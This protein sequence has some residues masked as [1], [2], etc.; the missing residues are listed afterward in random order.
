MLLEFVAILAAGFA[1][2]G[3]ALTLNVLLRR[4]LPKWVVPASAG[5]GMLAMAIWLEYSW[6]ERVTANLP[7]EVEVVSTNRLR[8]WYRPWTY[9]VP[10]VNRLIALD[11][12]F[13]RRNPALPDQVLTRVLLLG[14]WEPSRQFGVV[15]DCAGARR[16]DL[17]DEVAFAPDGGLA[18]ARW[19]ALPVDDALLRGA[20]GA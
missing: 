10:Q 13:D 14:R 15:L 12:R 9:V 6:F 20:C 3:I 4:R 8:A 11:H 17:T 5:A 2:A 1:L 18:G 19:I 16:A 7:Q